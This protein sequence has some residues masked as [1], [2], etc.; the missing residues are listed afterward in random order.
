MIRLRIATALLA[1]F[2]IALFIY[3]CR[4]THELAESEKLHAIGG[5]EVYKSQRI[6][7]LKS[8]RDRITIQDPVLRQQEIDAIDRQI[9]EI[10]NE[11]TEEMGQEMRRVK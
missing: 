10:E 1:S 3:S 5:V 8:I 2:T 6:A 7:A 9:S 11:V 4:L